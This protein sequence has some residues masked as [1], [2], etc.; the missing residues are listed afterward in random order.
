MNFNNLKYI[1]NITDWDGQWA[2]KNHPK[3]YYFRLNFHKNKN[4]ENQRVETNANK[5]EK[6]DLIILSQKK[7]TENNRYL[8]HIVEIVNDADNDKQQWDYDTNTENEW[9]IF[10][11][12]KVHWVADFNNVSSIPIDYDVMQVKDWGYQNTLAKLLEGNDNN[13]MRQWGDIETLRKHLE[14]IFRPLL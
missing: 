9:K 14:S 10:R 1:K 5:L 13:L 8:T 11:W 3:N 4:S 2:Y 7:E 6:G 12:V